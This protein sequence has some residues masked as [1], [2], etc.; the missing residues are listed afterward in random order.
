MREERPVPE[1]FTDLAMKE[2]V[3]TVPLVCISQ[4]ERSFDLLLAQRE[5][6]TASSMVSKVLPKVT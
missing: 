1:G 3:E 4:C 5:S 6:S 2:C